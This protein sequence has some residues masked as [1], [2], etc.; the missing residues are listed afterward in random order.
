MIATIAEQKDSEN[1]TAIAGSA[2]SLSF[3][4]SIAVSDNVIVFGPEKQLSVSAVTED[5]EDFFC[6]FDAAGVDA[7]STDLTSFFLARVSVCFGAL[8]ACIVL[9]FNDDIM[10]IVCFS[11]ES[12]RALSLYIDSSG[13]SIKN[14]KK[15]SFVEKKIG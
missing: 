1:F 6:L 2:S 5:G 10:K 8:L 11:I 4:A 3:I 12:R 15:L 13:Q 7:A 14:F 9:V